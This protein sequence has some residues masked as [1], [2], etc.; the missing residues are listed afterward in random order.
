MI[1]KWIASFN[2]I[3]SKTV[4]MDTPNASVSDPRDSTPPGTRLCQEDAIVRMGPQKI[5]NPESGRTSRKRS[6]RGS[7]KLPGQMSPKP[8]LNKNQQECEWGTYTLT[9]K[10]L[11][12]RC[13]SHYRAVECVYKWISS[14]IRSNKTRYCIETNHTKNGWWKEI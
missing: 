9:F 12:L 1:D 13:Q 10:I 14:G 2:V 11:N 5:P 4:S 3:P 6:P 7:E 8:T